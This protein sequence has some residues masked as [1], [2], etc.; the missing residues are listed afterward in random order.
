M[1]FTLV[2]TGYFAKEYDKWAAELTWFYFI[3]SLS[4]HLVDFVFPDQPVVLRDNP[5]R[6]AGQEVGPP[7]PADLRHVHELDRGHLLLCHLDD[8]NHWVHPQDT[9]LR[10]GVEVGTNDRKVSS[11][12]KL[13]IWI[14]QPL[15]F[16]GS[17]L[18]IGTSIPE[19]ISSLI[20]SRQGKGSMAVSNSIGSNTFD[21]LLCLGLPWLI[22]AS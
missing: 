16:F 17:F 20:V 6:A 19:V 4:P 18:A 9:G 13:I 5:R 11:K 7:L 15:R 3:F 8:L 14:T 10:H 2:F 12:K 21:I 22:Q 1:D